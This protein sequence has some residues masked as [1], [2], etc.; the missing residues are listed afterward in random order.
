MAKNFVVSDQWCRSS[1]RKAWK[2]SRV[3]CLLGW[4]VVRSVGRS[5]ACSTAGWLA[6]SLASLPGGLCVVCKLLSLQWATERTKKFMT[7]SICTQPASLSPF[8]LRN[9]FCHVPFN[10]YDPR[11]R[12]RL[13]G[14]QVEK[15]RSAL[16]CLARRELVYIQIAAAPKLR[17]AR[18]SAQDIRG[19]RIL[20]S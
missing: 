7:W 12:K 14:R 15:L 17:S 5:V 1:F 19:H 13:R 20:A 9:Y 10:V 2:A 4:L 16:R 8:L 6:F 18:G 3:G 11:R